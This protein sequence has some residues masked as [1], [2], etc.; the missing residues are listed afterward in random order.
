MAEEIV[1]GAEAPEKVES[2]IVI[3]RFEDDV[4]AMG[5]EIEPKQE[6]KEEAQPPKEEVKAEIKE[7]LK[8]VIQ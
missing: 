8:E 1:A 2:S 7:D 6:S 5:L 4:K 3:E